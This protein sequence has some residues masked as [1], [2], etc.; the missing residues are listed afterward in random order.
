MPR[1]F[2]RWHT[3]QALAGLEGET[4]SRTDMVGTFKP[5]ALSEAKPNEIAKNLS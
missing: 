1:D 4:D 3:K 5:T 2:P